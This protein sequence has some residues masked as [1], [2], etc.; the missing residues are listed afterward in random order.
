MAYD[1]NP[2]MARERG[3]NQCF[4]QNRVIFEIFLATKTA[5]SN[6]IKQI[7]NENRQFTIDQCL[8]FYSS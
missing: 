1:D 2:I 8:P 3:C 7:K 5:L 4:A 6:A